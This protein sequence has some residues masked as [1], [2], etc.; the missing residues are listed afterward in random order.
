M[1]GE[2]SAYGKEVAIAPVGLTVALGVYN[3][4]AH[5]VGARAEAE[6]ETQALAGDKVGPRVNQGCSWHIRSAV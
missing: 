3:R 2:T 6:A 5:I 1:T 4:D